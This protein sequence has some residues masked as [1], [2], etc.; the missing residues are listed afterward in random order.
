[1]RKAILFDIDGTVLDAE[2][3]IFGPVRNNIT[4]YKLSYPSDAKIKKALGKPLTQF[5]E[6]LIPGVDRALLSL[7]AKTHREFQEKN[8]HLIKPYNKTKDTLKKLRDKGFLLAAVSN[9]FRAGLVQSLKS[10]EIF[11]Y[12]DAIVC[13]DDVKNPKPHQEHLL[14]ALEQLQVESDNAYMV[15]DTDQDILGGKNAKVKTVGVTYGFAGK[16]ISKYKPDFLINT[17]EE[18]LE[19]LK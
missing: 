6:I 19:I 17:I 2:D 18:I 8:P 16:D 13:A 15:G 1:M 9:R 5:Y 3:F 14:V 10:T 7:L 12:F 11:D 4:T